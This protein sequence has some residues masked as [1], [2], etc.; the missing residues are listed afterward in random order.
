MLAISGVLV[1]SLVEEVR[2]SSFSVS[3]IRGVRMTR[4]GDWARRVSFCLPTARVYTLGGMDTMVERRR[5]CGSPPFSVFFC[6]VCTP[7]P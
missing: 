5:M 3:V 7:V 1:S 4:V 6:V 2:F